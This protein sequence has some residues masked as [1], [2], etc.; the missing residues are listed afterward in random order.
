MANQFSRTSVPSD[1][2]VLIVGAGSAHL[3]RHIAQALLARSLDVVV[4]AAG[5]GRAHPDAQKLL[6][7]PIVRQR[8][9]VEPSLLEDFACVDR[10]P[11]HGWYQQFAGRR[12]RP[13]RY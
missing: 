4:A 1:A 6:E 2:R 9:V 5:D 11:P 13:P 10:T 7:V 3:G 8:L 12:G